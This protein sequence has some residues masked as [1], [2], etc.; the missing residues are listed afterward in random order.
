LKVRFLHGPSK[1]P[2]NP[3][4]VLASSSG[5]PPKTCPRI[6]VRCDGARGRSTP[7]RPPSGHAFKITSSAS[8]LWTLL[9]VARRVP[10]GDHAT[11]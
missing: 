2:Q 3:R 7:Y 5:T 8:L 9:A 6:G 11:P 4:V 10:S 1:V